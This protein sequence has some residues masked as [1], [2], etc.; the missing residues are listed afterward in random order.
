MN[1][2][3]NRRW[4]ERLVLAD[5]DNGYAYPLGRACECMS[6]CDVGVYKG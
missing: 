1:G 3:Q 5:N 2:N 6:V 4:W